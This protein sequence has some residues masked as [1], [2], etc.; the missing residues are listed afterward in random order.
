MRKGR[1]CFPVITLYNGLKVNNYNLVTQ[2]FYYRRK[3]EIY[4]SYMIY[5]LVT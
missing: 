3:R 1:E 5:I 4:Y 2:H